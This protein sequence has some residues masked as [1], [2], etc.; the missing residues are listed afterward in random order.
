MSRLHACLFA[1]VST[2][3]TGCGEQNLP[4][5]PVE[6]T[7]LF[8]DDS[9][10]AGGMVELQSI[11]HQLNA[12]GQID[13]QGKFRLTTFVQ[14]DGAVAGR[15]KV[16]VIQFNIVEEYSQRH[17]HH[18]HSRPA[19]ARKYAAYETSGLEIEVQPGM[20]NECRLVVERE[21]DSTSH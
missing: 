20:K 2:I 21:A 4:T 14:N 6:G 1:I 9:P 12:V 3:A 8:A 11:D 16:V 17:R 7:V 18:S 10:V 5:Y 15:H 19:V 13:S